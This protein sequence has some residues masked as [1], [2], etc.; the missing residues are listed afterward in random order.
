MISYDAVG[1]G[2]V[3]SLLK[4]PNFSAFAEKGMLFRDIQT[5]F[6][7]NTYPVH[8]SVA[9]GVSPCEHGLV[10]NQ[11]IDPSDPNPRW[12]YRS[13]LIKKK[14][15]WQ[16]AAE[17]GLTTAAVLWPVTGGAKEI[18]W[19]I[20][21]TMAHGGEN[22]IKLNLKYG[23]KILQV[24]ELFRHK[25]LMNGIHQPE[26]DR[27]STACMVDIIREKE[28][29]LMLLHLTAYDSMCHIYGR[30]SAESIAV[31]KEMDEH[32]RSLLA[33]ID[34]DTTVIIFSDHAQLN[35]HTVINPNHILEKANFAKVLRDGS[36][37]HYSCYFTLQDGSAFFYRNGCDDSAVDRVR[38]LTLTTEGVR[39]ILTEDEMKESGHTDAAFG[40]CAE[41]GFHFGTEAN[42]RG[43][44][45]YPTDYPDYST[46]CAISEPIQGVEIK[47]IT[48]IT[49]IAAR[50]LD[51]QM[52]GDSL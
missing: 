35:V 40:V 9:T 14:T 47:K 42:K 38:D 23:S 45:G 6:V 52:Q 13:A 26:L 33:A 3:P 30:G 19:N 7:S 17:K 4:L 37:E 22:Q 20:P 5:V 15:L 32:L 28:P 12:N 10:D 21:E 25:N 29:D 2:D 8:V 44:H 34:S 1:S 49:G 39:R 11:E 16:A 50:I 51:L 27:F 43:S 48:D 36:L 41:V 18:R 31:L 46:F 24:S